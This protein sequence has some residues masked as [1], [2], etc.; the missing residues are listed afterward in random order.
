MVA[1]LPQ[2]RESGT[3]VKREVPEC[4]G[5]MEPLTNSRPENKLD[6]FRLGGWQQRRVELQGASTRHEVRA[7]E[8]GDP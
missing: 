1:R 4:I 7:G 6:S 8:G 2:R 5:F 3:L